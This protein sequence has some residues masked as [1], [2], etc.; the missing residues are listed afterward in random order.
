VFNTSIPKAA[1]L[2]KGN[3][4]G[5]PGVL[6]Q[7]GHKAAEAYLNVARSLVHGE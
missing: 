4:A 3:A 6:L 2:D 1:I 5:L 7:P